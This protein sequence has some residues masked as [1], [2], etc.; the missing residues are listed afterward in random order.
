MTRGSLESPDGMRPKTKPSAEHR[1]RLKPVGFVYVAKAV[2]ALTRQ[3]PRKK[4]RENNAR[5][6]LRTVKS[7]SRAHAFQRGPPP[8]CNGDGHPDTRPAPSPIVPDRHFARRVATVAG[9]A[10]VSPQ[11]RLYVGHF[12]LILAACPV[13]PALFVRTELRKKKVK[14]K[15]R[16]LVARFCCFSPYPISSP[17]QRMRV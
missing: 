15:E 8:L 10:N 14:Q 3:P 17:P 1:C 16:K 13:V 5:T 4:K 6:S 7:G 9:V 11:S 2:C 12:M